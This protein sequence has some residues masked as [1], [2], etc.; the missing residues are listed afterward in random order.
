M[1]E[2]GGNA[3]DAAVASGLVLQVV[4][5]S[6]TGIGG[7][8]VI[9]AARVN[10]NAPD[11]LCGQGPAPGSATLE[12]FASQGFAKIPHRGK[13]SAVV[14]GAFG[15]WLTL[16]R[17]Y[18]TLSLEEVMA[19]A[20]YYASTG[21][22]V[23]D[24]LHQEIRWSA[25]QLASDSAIAAV[26]YLPKGKPPAIGDY[27][28]NVALANA[29]SAIL[30]ETRSASGRE[31]Q[32]N[33]GIACFYRGY[34]ADAVDSFVRSGCEAGDDAF[35]GRGFL[36]GQDMADWSVVCEKPA[37]ITFGPY[38][39]YKPGAWSQGPVLLQLLGTLGYQRYSPAEVMTSEH[40]HL[41]A[42]IMKLCYADREAYYGDPDFVDV[43]LDVLLSEGYA[44]DRRKLAGPNA[45]QGICPG[46]INGRKPKL[47]S[48][49]E[50]QIAGEYALSP[51][52]RDTSHVSIVD[53]WGNVASATPSGGWF[54]GSPVVPDL[55]FSLSTRAEMFWLQPDLASSLR[56]GSRPRTTIAPTMVFKE[57]K[58]ILA[59][60][61]R[62]ADFSEQ[63]QFQFLT[64]YLLAGM[65]LQDAIE[66]P[67]FG[68]QHWP[69]SEYPRTAKPNLI[70]ID[71]RIDRVVAG[72]LAAR[73]HRI[74]TPG[75]HRLG[76]ICAVSVADGR[77]RAAV[78]GRI[79]HYLA[80]GR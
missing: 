30:S 80:V 61:T 57:G 1:L 13:V 36:T 39:I 55:G 53:K 47:P 60:G 58:P 35:S 73:G 12:S 38:T 54:W 69:D 32:I 5:P 10:C 70:Q 56:P 45:A 33:A 6:S 7:E 22:P 16:L 41:S 11:V 2:L 19:P 18:G 67:M 4:E 3:F 63:W 59:F 26:I 42:E 78:T 21:C 17:D 76:R 27:I 65:S 77:M 51:I 62:G 20:I 40:I 44:E 71:S 68:L 50:E 43:P 52:E 66:S 29:Y 28:R 15:A 8:V 46:K 37:Q 75:A 9:L 24:T 34:I 31:A 49:D 48:Y 23:T 74:K 72:E 25:K 79:S 64:K 14:P